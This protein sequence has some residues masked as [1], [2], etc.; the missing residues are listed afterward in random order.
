MPLDEDQRRRRRNRQVLTAVAFGVVAATLTYVEWSLD[1]FTTGELAATA[2]VA[3][4]IAI[5]LLL[6]GSDRVVF[7]DEGLVINR[8]HVPWAAV[9]SIKWLYEADEMG[10]ASR[11]EIGLREAAGYKPP[12]IGRLRFD[13]EHLDVTPGDFWAVAQ[14]RTPH[15][16]LLLNGPPGSGTGL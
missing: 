5:W 8:R 9:R 7:D 1:V 14:E 12:R 10:P 11:I 16:V 15:H 4:L 3:F 2:T 13:P 6:P